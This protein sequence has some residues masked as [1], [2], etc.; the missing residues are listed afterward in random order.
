MNTL[1]P[2]KYYDLKYSVIPDNKIR[3]VVGA[4]TEVVYTSAAT[5]TSDDYNHYV[6]KYRDGH[7]GTGSLPLIG[8]TV[9]SLYEGDFYVDAT[10]EHNTGFSFDQNR[11]E[12]VA[13]KYTVTVLSDLPCQFSGSVSDLAVVD[14]EGFTYTSEGDTEDGLVAAVW[15][16]FDGDDDKLYAPYIQNS[17]WGPGYNTTE[18]NSAE[19]KSVS[20]DTYW[21][22][23][24]VDSNLGK[25]KMILYV[26]VY[27]V[28][29]TLQSYRY[30]SLNTHF[31]YHGVMNLL[32]SFRIQVTYYTA[33]TVEHD[34]DYHTQD[35][36][37]ALYPLKV[38]G[39][40]YTNGNTSYNG[41]SWQQWISNQILEKYEDG[42]IF[43]SAKIKASYLVENQLD[44]NSE[45][46]I[47]DIDNRFINR[48]D[49]M[50]VFQLKNIEYE[51]SGSEFIANV[52]LLED[53]TIEEML[54]NTGFEYIIAQITEMDVTSKTCAMIIID[55]P[56]VITEIRGEMEHVQV[57]SIEADK[58]LAYFDILLTDMQSISPNIIEGDTDFGFDIE[59][60]T[61]SRE[62]I[63]F[64]AKTSAGAL[65]I[66]ISGQTRTTKSFDSCVDFGC[67]LYFDPY[68]FTKVHVSWELD[69]AVDVVNETMAAAD[70][71]QTSFENTL[72]PLVNNVA[73][74]CI[75]SFHF[76][77]DL[78]ELAY[79]NQVIPSF[80]E[81]LLEPQTHLYF[82]TSES[83]ITTQFSIIKDI[84]STLFELS[85]GLDIKITFT[86]LMDRPINDEYFFNVSIEDWIDLSIENM[87]EIKI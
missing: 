60:S 59:V 79:Y 6:Y 72:G 3:Q 2:R 30:Q 42:K 54:V 28:N 39:N 4:Y 84:K 15:E 29:N 75:D 78:L 35:A 32:W 71:K 12:K 53:R 49:K 63:P 58:T 81:N 7:I 14:V 51:Y 55:K 8:P 76:S 20:I 85:S 61:A 69:Y 77:I 33:T 40:E 82:G 37:Y 36:D 65:D 31:V 43:I 66:S 68:S 22:G 67:D 87:L 5:S 38:S 27:V 74:L 9:S 70:I 62:Q 48:L 1:K 86:R 41:T 80:R 64:E 52:I 10:Y 19:I 46:L 26:E 23:K 50:C 11:T 18:L 16:M 25:Y 34:F 13:V 73:A 17:Q 57:F 47:K 24:K 44:I 21:N 56:T 83:C 45:M